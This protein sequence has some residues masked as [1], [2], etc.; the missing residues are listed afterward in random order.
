MNV[1]DCSSI[2][3]TPNTSSQTIK[4]SEYLKQSV[5]LKEKVVSSGIFQTNKT[6]TSSGKFFSVDDIP[7]VVP[8]FMQ[9]YLNDNA[10]GA[11]NAGLIVK[12]L[13]AVDFNLKLLFI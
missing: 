2:L 7:V 8:S 9:K 13:F 12:F 3:N 5:S 10:E 6:T 11:E 4:N 1:T